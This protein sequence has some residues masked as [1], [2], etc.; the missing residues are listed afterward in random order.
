MHY[1]RLAFATLGILYG[2][3]SYT[4]A[5]QIPPSLL[6]MLLAKE[7]YGKALAEPITN[8]VARR[9]T[10]HP[11]F[12]GCIDWHSSVHGHWAL[13][14]L[15]RAV[16]D[17]TI[18]QQGAVGFCKSRNPTG[19]LEAGRPGGLRDAV[20]PGLV[21][22]VGNRT[23]TCEKGLGYRTICESSLAVAYAVFREQPPGLSSTDYKSATW[24]LVNMLDYTDRAG[25]TSDKARILA[26]IDR[27]INFWD[28]DCSY[29]E[30]TGSFMA[31]CT[32]IALLASRVLEP[33][34]YRRWSNVYLEQVGLPEPVTDPV[35]WHHHGLNF[36]RSWGL[37]ELYSATGRLEFANAY[38]AHFLETIK[39]PA[40]WRGN[41]RGVGHWV[42][43][44]GVFALQPLFGRDAG[45]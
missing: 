25:L 7:Q 43:Q 8:C 1:A 6:P 29:R 34:D 2:V 40:Q 12:H 20:W 31:L 44:F 28:L 45:R 26:Q 39:K 27:E 35:S 5:S 4:H 23:Y 21:P 36:S 16:P 19:N 22:A 13:L 38:A 3:T 41:Y 10:G 17:I 15:N 24:A 11:V 32:N 42:A 14:A 18:P 37:W 9:D 30:E 33:E